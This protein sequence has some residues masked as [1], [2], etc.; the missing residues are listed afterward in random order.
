MAFLAFHAGI[1][2]FGQAHLRCI[3][4]NGNV[5]K[6]AGFGYA[7]MCVCD[8]FR[9]RRF[10]RPY[11][12]P[13]KRN[14]PWYPQRA[15]WIWMFA[16]SRGGKYPQRSPRWKPAGRPPSPRIPTINAAGQQTSMTDA[17]GNATTYLYDNAGREL[18]VTQPPVE[19]GGP[20]TVTS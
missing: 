16:P 19:T 5:R 14:F 15:T 6:I 4:T 20:S 17:N 13:W 18:S 8:D 2:I 3:G 12:L 10:D 11:R 7:L 1:L 9:L